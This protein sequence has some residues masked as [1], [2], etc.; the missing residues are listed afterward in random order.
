MT[1]VPTSIGATIK[2]GSRHG[3][4]PHR[5]DSPSPS[6]TLEIDDDALGII[7]GSIGYRHHRLALP[8]TSSGWKQR[9]DAD[10]PAHERAVTVAG[11]T[12]TAASTTA[13][14]TYTEWVRYKRVRSATRLGQA[15]TPPT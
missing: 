15:R 8:A 4:E 7:G 10:A 6:G 1:A 9:G 11:G 13:T 5:C 14:A 12:P 3:R 2:D